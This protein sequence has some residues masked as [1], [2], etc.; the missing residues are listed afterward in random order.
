MIL[1]ENPDYEKFFNPLCCKNK[2]I[3]YECILQLIEKSKQVPLLYENDARDTLTLYFRNLSYA[4]EDEDNSG[5]ADENISSKKSE[6]EQ[7]QVVIEEKKA[8]TVEKPVED[9]QKNPDHTD[10]PPSKYEQ[11]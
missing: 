10:N 11:F 6:K 7:E 8:Y 2:K 4:V 5:N 3:Y 9:A 1:F